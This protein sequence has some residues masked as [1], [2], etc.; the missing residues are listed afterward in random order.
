M[1]NI[2]KA[3]KISD[4]SADVFAL[5]RNKWASYA[6]SRGN[7]LEIGSTQVTEV[8][9]LN[10]INQGGLSNDR[11]KLPLDGGIMRGALTP[12]SYTNIVRF[13]VRLVILQR[14]LEVGQRLVVISITVMRP[15]DIV[16]HRSRPTL[17]IRIGR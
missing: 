15:A 17:R 11:T 14:L 16:A 13:T 12:A 5:Q 7:P 3:R 1:G 10:Q 2:G 9:A 8:G 6:V 4:D